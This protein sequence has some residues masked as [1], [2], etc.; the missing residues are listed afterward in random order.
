MKTTHAFFAAVAA[1]L[2]FAGAA[3]AGDPTGT[4]TWS[5]PGRDGQTMESTMKL[6][7]KDGKLTGTVS[8]F[9]GGD[10]AISD[11][12]FTDDAIAFKVVAEFN[13]NKRTATYEG[14]LAGDTITGTILIPGRDGGEPRK[15]DWNATRK[16]T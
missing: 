10:N 12:T 14:K 4:W 7:L 1:A 13:G 16:K 3:F 11:A 2:L 15:V 6:E 8:G 5:R 9:R